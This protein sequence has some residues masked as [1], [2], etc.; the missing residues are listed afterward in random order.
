[1][2]G[3]RIGFLVLFSI[4]IICFL[5]QFGYKTEFINFLG[6][7]SCETTSPVLLMMNSLFFK[8]AFLYAGLRLTQLRTLFEHKLFTITPDCECP[9]SSNL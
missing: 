7:T 4:F 5:D 3:Y 8:L 2:F 1:M 6:A 9:K